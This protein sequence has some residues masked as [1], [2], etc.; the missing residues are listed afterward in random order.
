MNLR[1]QIATLMRYELRDE[2]RGGEVGFV[3][4]PFGVVALLTIPMAIGID[5][6]LLQRI[7][8]G[9]YWSIILLFGVLVTQRHS[10]L[11]PPATRDMLRLAGADPVARFAA[12]TLATFLLLLAFEVGAG[13]ATMALYDPA[14]DSWW[15]LAALLPL[16]AAGLSMIGT[17]AGNIASGLEARTSLVPLIVVPIAV[18]LLLGAAQATEGLRV[19][20]G[21]LRWLLLLAIVDTVLAVAGV[22]TARS[23]EESAA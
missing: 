11:A 20:A 15:W 13:F 1:N 22:L 21:I 19:G 10:S 18:P 12:T 6:P 14:L 8:P 9:I 16:T 4:L 3:V 23:L 5:T 7:G 17:I 2:L